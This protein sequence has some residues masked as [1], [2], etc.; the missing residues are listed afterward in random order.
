[1]RITTP[2]LYLAAFD[3]NTHGERGLSEGEGLYKVNTTTKETLKWVEKGCSAGEPVF[4]AAPSAIRED[5]GVVLAVVLDHAHHDSFLLVLD[6]GSFKE[7]ARARAPHLIP[8]G[9]HGQY[10]QL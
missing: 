5:E 8:N 1:M 4:V 10:F 3:S 6:A 2:Y 7:I 9:F